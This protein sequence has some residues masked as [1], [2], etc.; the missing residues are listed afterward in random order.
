[1]QGRKPNIVFLLSDQH[2]PSV[3]G[4]YGNETVRTPNIDR[5]AGEGVVFDGF[6]CNSP[7]CVPSRMSMMTGRYPWKIDVLNNGHT[8]D[9]RIPT[10][11]HM[12]AGAGYRTALAGRMHFVGSDQ[13][14]GFQERVGGDYGLYAYHGGSPTN[15]AP[16]AVQGNPANGSQPAPLLYTGAGDTETIE[17][18][19]RTNAAARDWLERYAR[20]DGE[21]PFLLTVGYFSP[22]C[23]YIAPPEYYRRYEG[24][25]RAPAFTDEDYARL[26]PIHK[27][28]MERCGARTAP[29]ENLDR[30]AAAYYGLVDYLDDLVGEVL[31]TLDARGLLDNTIVIYSSDH[32]E[33]LGA[34]G[35]WH[36]DSF[37]EES[38]RVPFIV[39]Y[40]D[41]SLRRR[42][43]DPSSLVD[44]FPTLLDLCEAPG[45]GVQLDG[46]S[47]VP[48][49]QGAS[50]D[51][52]HVVRC[53]DY[54]LGCN[55]MVR[56]GNAKL[57]FYSEHDRRELYDLADDP[58]EI[59]NRID[60]P[61]Y[62]SVRDML[63]KALFAD[64][65]NADVLTDTEA[66][67][68]AMGFFEMSKNTWQSTKL[69]Q[70]GV[71]TEVPGYDTGML[72]YRSVLA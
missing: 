35:R 3:T 26:H 24:I 55:R 2:T 14:H 50:R 62:A 49:M 22:H 34:H 45:S 28:Y 33:M 11:A 61:D 53:E 57:C 56:Q 15:F 70:E 52:A 44:L 12:A 8:L 36:K 67:L 10:F 20:E 1:M 29:R 23:P 46:A 37:F 58:G 71:L 21:H 7:L 65:W 43:A 13:R 39:R 59:R 25:V 38:A 30:A 41:R 5:L 68:T 18:D 27:A 48:L 31:A 4:C 9:S 32:G 51:P 69:V 72:D 66:R 64:G 63:A 40:P 6:Y 47:L 42:V 16:L 54:F 17:L 19:R 60:D